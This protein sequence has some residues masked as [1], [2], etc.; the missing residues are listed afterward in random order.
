MKVKINAQ[1]IYDKYFK[2][3]QAQPRGVVAKL[4]TIVAQIERACQ[5]QVNVSLFYGKK[6][7]EYILLENMKIT[8][9]VHNF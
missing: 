9:Q 4:G 8:V 1:E 6:L 3:A 5:K 7:G 2:V